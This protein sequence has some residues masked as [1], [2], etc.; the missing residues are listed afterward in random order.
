MILEFGTEE[1]K[2]QHLPAILKGEEI[3]MQF[4]SE[5][6][7]GSDVAG[8]LTTA[9]RDGDEWLLNGSKVWTTGAWWSDWGLVPG[10]DQ[11]GRARSTVASRSS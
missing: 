7:G 1:Q 5:P 10:P 8:A 9:V 2:R 6:S 11:L 3:W 4:L